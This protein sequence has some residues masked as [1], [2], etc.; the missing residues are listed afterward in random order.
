[1]GK[2]NQKVNMLRALIRVSLNEGVVYPN[3]IKK[4]SFLFSVYLAFFK[5][6]EI[7]LY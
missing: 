4:Y 3:H 1:M 2:M 6:R 7:Q 5:V